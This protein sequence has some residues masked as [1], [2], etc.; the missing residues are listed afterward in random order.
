M[1]KKFENSESSGEFEKECERLRREH[2][3]FRESLKA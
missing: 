1:A 3:D 2:R